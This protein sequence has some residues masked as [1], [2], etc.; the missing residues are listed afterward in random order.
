MHARVRESLVGPRLQAE[1]AWLRYGLAIGLL[2]CTAFARAE[3]TPL[4]GRHS[5]LLPFVLPVL[6]TC[7][8]S[9]RGPAWLI[10]LISPVLCTVQFQTDFRWSDSLG[11]LAHVTFFVLVCAALIEILHRLQVTHRRL[12]ESEALL[13]EADRRKNEFLAML[14]HELRNPLAPILNIA[15]IL[16]TRAY[17]PSTVQQMSGVLQRQA[18]HLARLVDDLL[19]VARITRDKIEL[20]RQNLVAQDVIERALE[21]A[22]PMFAARRQ[23]VTVDAPSEPLKIDGD[24][25]RLTQAVGNLLTNAAKFS[26]DGARIHVTAARAED[27]QVEIRVRDEGAGID[28]QILPHVFDLFVQ[29][30]QSLD[31]SQGGLGIGLTVAKR[32]IELH[33]GRIEVTSAGTDR[34][35]EF[36]ITLPQGVLAARVPEEQV[37]ATAAARRILVVDDNADAAMSLAVLLR[38]EGHEVVTARDGPAA[39]RELEHFDAQLVLLDIGLPGI[40]GYALADLIRQ[41]SGA[42]TPHLVALS[43]YVEARDAEGGAVFDAYLTKPLEL[44]RLTEVLARLPA[45][46]RGVLSR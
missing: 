8:L 36:T 10:A 41:R 13:L 43:G 44:A 26:P 46:Q 12:L 20:Q 27:G 1:P 16:R 3:L 4:I 29:G 6:V 21:A 37:E 15:P 22:R 32:L 33:G 24:R 28:A 30:D 31:R 42:A 45:A 9:G 38:M 14:A 7:Y 18:S 25:V 19:D 34:G 2:V 11:W 17:E 40:D 5:P 39:L 35:S 23:S